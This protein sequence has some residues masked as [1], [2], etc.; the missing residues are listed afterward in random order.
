MILRPSRGPTPFRGVEIS[1]VSAIV[2]STGSPSRNA[3]FKRAV[4]SILSQS[5]VR[6]E[7]IVV[8]NGVNL[9][10]T[11][12]EW[13]QSQENTRHVILSQADKARATLC[14]RRLV[15]G[16]FFC[17][18]DD[19]DEF[20]PG[21]FERSAN[22]LQNT[23]RLDC[24]ASNGFY[25]T[26]K[27]VR[28]VFSRADQF[29]RDGYVESLL[30]SRNWLASCGGMFRSV[31]VGPEYFE[32]LPRHREWTVIA[33]RIATNLQV[34]FVNRLS[35][36][37]FSLADSQSKRASYMDAATEALAVMLEA[38][39][40]PRRAQLI[41]R[42]TSIAYHSIA[43]YYRHRRDFRR[44]WAAYWSA[45]RSSGGWKYL[46]YAALLIAREARP[47][48]DVLQRLS[49]PHTTGECNPNKKAASY[50]PAHV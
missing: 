26:A 15:R 3:E 9:D 41:R 1:L 11:L 27:G 24:L 32:N 40:D 16:E 36:R 34:R 23:P 7:C 22:I 20:L 46:P 14:G 33:Y 30:R 6:A 43:S 29:A 21:A 17:F 39:K 45:V 38:T 4:R 47:A 42:R 48:K 28:C 13:V 10:D 44:A 18:L 35:Y 31:S 8:F 5:G 49:R 25:V 12:V 19:D 2:R 37:I 50:P